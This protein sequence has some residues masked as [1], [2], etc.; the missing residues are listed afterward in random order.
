M[1]TPPRASDFSPENARSGCASVPQASTAMPCSA[2]PMP[3]VMMMPRSTSLPIGRIATRSIST[4][5][6]PITS[7]ATAIAGSAGN[8]SAIRPIAPSAPSD[9]KSP[10]AKLTIP[11]TL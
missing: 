9:A 5:S 7:T 8:P 2:T 6:R 1:V 10:C 11:V 3:M 4:P